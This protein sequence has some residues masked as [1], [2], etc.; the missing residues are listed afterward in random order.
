MSKFEEEFKKFLID[1]PAQNYDSIL[2][3]IQTK[4]DWI[5]YAYGYGSKDTPSAIYHS[6]DIES[7]LK[8]VVEIQWSDRLKLNY[9]IDSKYKLIEGFG[10]NLGVSRTKRAQYQCCEKDHE[11]FIT[12]VYEGKID[13]TNFIVYSD[14][15]AEKLREI[16]DQQLEEKE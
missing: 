4:I 5:F 11:T 12:S 6:C 2:S 10:E 16:R 1:E 9:K 8:N 15:V 7:F 3:F 13:D 14:E